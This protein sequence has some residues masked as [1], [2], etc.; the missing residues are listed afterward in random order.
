LAYGTIYGI[1]VPATDFLQDL[2]GNGRLGVYMNHSMTFSCPNGYLHYSK[3]VN[4]AIIEQDRVIPFKPSNGPLLM[5]YDE[6]T[7]YVYMFYGCNITKI[8]RKFSTFNL[9]K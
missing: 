8:E 7:D 3:S 5:A 4:S 9:K 6:L 1:D 2:S